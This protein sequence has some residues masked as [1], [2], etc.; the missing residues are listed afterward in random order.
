MV[1]LATTSFPV[2]YSVEENLKTYVTYIEQAASQGAKLI[3]FPE[4]SLQGYLPT[5]DEV[6]EE[7]RSY[8]T[9]HA[10]FVPEGASTQYLIGKAKEHDLYIVWGTTETDGE[11]LYNTAV[12]VGP[13]G[14][15]GKYRKVHQP[16]CESQ[17]YTHGT[18]FDVFDTAIGKIGLLICYDKAFPESARELYVQGAEIICQPAAWPM[19]GD[20]S[21][22]DDNDPI[23]DI[24]N[25]YDKTR[26]AENAVFFISCNQCGSAGT[27][28]YCG[29]SR[30][31]HPFGMELACTG[32]GEGI[33]YAEADIQEA[34][35]MAGDPAVRLDRHL[36]A[37]QNIGKM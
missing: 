22:P 8:Q 29:H 34:I 7:T 2:V 23:L 26:A 27:I 3:V 6:T 15:V 37:Y 4:Q 36:E 33:V 17:I 20:P 19:A 10:E 21:S 25:M 24:Y 35:S 11:H 13:E 14:Y 16:G 31:T 18:R 30:I 32:W 1:K 28:H 9:A 12:L 5:L